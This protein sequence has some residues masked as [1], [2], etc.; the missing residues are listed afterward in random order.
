[1]DAHCQKVSSIGYWIGVV[2]AFMYPG[3]AGLMVGWGIS[4]LCAAIAG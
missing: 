3:F 1:M 4:A 2:I